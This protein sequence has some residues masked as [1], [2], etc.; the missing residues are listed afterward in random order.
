M[1]IWSF[2]FVPRRPIWSEGD[3]YGAGDGGDP[4]RWNHCVTVSLAIILMRSLVVGSAKFEAGRLEKL[5]DAP[6][7][8]MLTWL[9]G[10]T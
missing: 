10:L 9:T 4:R 8:Q 6:V 3:V 7:E 5:E 2:L 1:R